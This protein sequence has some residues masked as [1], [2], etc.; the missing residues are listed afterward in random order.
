M[1]DKEKPV[2][3]FLQGPASPF[4]RYF[5]DYLESQ[6][7]TCLRVN[8]A[9]SDWVQW[10]GK[11]SV[12][13]RGTFTDWPEFL[14]DYIRR[15]QVTCILYYADCFP[16]HKVARVVADQMGIDAVAY[17]NGYLR[18]NWLTI[19]KGGMSQFS[20]FPADA[21]V[22]LKLAEGLP[23]PQEKTLPS[24]NFWVEAFWEV[25]YNLGNY[26]F[27]WTFPH[28]E[29][30]KYYN[31][32]L[33]YLSIIPRLVKGRWL[34][35]QATGVIEKLIKGKHRY[36]VFPLQMQNDYQLRNNSRFDHQSQ[37]L[38]EVIAAFARSAAA[39]DRLVI[40]IHPTDNGIEP[41]AKFIQ[42]FA[43][44]YG[45]VDRIDFIDGGNLKRLIKHCRGLITI[46]STVGLHALQALKPVLVLGCTIYDIAGIAAQ[47]D[48]DGF[49]RS[50]QKPDQQLLQAFVRLLAISIQ[51]KGN[52]YTR[53]GAVCAIHEMSRKLLDKQINSHGA[54]ELHPARARDKCGV[55]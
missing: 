14:G 53:E 18:P 6:G 31:P 8:L 1:A 32:F 40:K 9:F 48:L 13:Y 41:W 23:D 25:T 7:A 5:A 4:S 2:F 10:L 44:Q 21:G 51:V 30:D 43:V 42:R 19:E 37:A 39:T 27:Q 12:N 45:V 50:P 38:E 20:H 28:F 49:F 47:Q 3:L 46:N 24:M 16:Y 54:F 17:E 29:A 33:D 22:L 55:P 26:F 34:E 11:P 36:W 15:H 52:F 35:A